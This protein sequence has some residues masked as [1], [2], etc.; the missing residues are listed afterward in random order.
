MLTGFF[1]FK[2]SPAYP[3]HRGC[4]QSKGQVVSCVL[5]GHHDRGACTRPG[6]HAGRSVES[7]ASIAGR[8]GCLFLQGRAQAQASAFPLMCHFD[9]HVNLLDGLRN[10]QRWLQQELIVLPLKPLNRKRSQV[11]TLACCSSDGCAG[12]GP[13]TPLLK[14]SEVIFGISMMSCQLSLVCQGLYKVC[15][16]G[17]G[18]QLILQVVAR[19]S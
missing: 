5:L 1:H 2:R 16:L 8:R 6:L 9:A 18:L 11:P 15:P 14:Q 17:A 7:V 3:F 19:Q 10:N 13:A 12:P 4:H